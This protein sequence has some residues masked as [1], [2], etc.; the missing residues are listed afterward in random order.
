[1]AGLKFEE[2]LGRLEETV[3][4]LE[5]PDLSLDASMKTF[6]EGIRLSK[7]C[8]KMLE[9]AER[10]V[11]ALTQDHNAPFQPASPSVSPVPGTQGVQQDDAAGAQ[12]EP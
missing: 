5:S 1:M 6:E 10:K 3:R 4:S 7:S 11:E 12:H 8:L 9:D 2:A